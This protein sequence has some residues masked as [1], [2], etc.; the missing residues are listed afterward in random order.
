MNSQII[1]RARVAQSGEVFTADREVKAMC[2]LVKEETGQVATKFLEPACGDGNFL[3]EIL[4]RKINSIL[5]EVT[6]G[7]ENKIILLLCAL[8]NIYG[9]DILTD[10]IQSCRE[11]LFAIWLQAYRTVTFNQVHQ[12]HSNLAQL[13]IRHNVVCGD[14]INPYTVDVNGLVTDEPLLS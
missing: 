11:R 3:A 6:E 9:I 12:E 8:S 10:N 1:D 14:F 2:D 4:T 5:N 7:K 13:I